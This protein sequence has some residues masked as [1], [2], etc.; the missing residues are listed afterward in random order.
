MSEEEQKYFKDLISFTF[1]T[2]DIKYIEKIVDK[3]DKEIE[4]LNKELEE[5]KKDFNE[6]NDLAYKLMINNKEYV[7]KSIKDTINTLVSKIERLNNI[8]KELDKQNRQLGEKLS[9]TTDKYEKKL[10]IKENII[11]EVREYIEPLVE[12]DNDIML[13]GKMLKPVLELVKENK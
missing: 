12:L 7:Q 1:D 13:K 2:D 6:A 5:Y 11:K 3:K 8:I 4:R 9:L 10:F